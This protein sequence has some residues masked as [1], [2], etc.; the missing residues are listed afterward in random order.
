M[1][2]FNT[3]G[4]VDHTQN[5]TKFSKGNEVDE[6]INVIADGNTSNVEGVQIGEEIN[7]VSI[8]NIVNDEVI[9]EVVTGNVVNGE[10]IKKVATGNTPNIDGVEEND[11][12]EV[13]VGEKETSQDYTDFLVNVEISSDVDDEVEGIR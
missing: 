1:E 12:D 2:F 10:V 4:I 13:H 9:N 5:Y 3:E 7:E 6:D 11:E 8:S